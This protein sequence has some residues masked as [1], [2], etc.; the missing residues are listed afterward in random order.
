[1]EYLE[2][3]PIR[4][5]CK[6]ELFGPD[7]VLKDKREIHN[8]V[9]A[10]FKNSAADQF[11]AAPALLK[12][13]HG[14]IGTGTHTPPNSLGAE[15]DVNTFTTKTRSTN[16]LIMVT[17]WA[18]GDG[19]GALTEAAIKDGAAGNIF[20]SVTFAVVNKLAADTLKITWN[21]DFN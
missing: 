16:R 17:D 6:I 8:A 20:A 14:A 10:N 13:T 19:T 5:N 1:M 21:V 4:V 2:E 11:L 18:A 12:P 7:G 3:L 15:L 9:H